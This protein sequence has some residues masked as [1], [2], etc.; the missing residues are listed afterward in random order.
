M[1]NEIRVYFTAPNQRVVKTHKTMSNSDATYGICN[2]AATLTAAKT[3][4]DRAFKLYVRMNLHQDKYTYALSPVEI[5][6][7]I[8]MSDKRYREAVKELIEKGYLV[9]SADHP[10]FFAFYEYP[11]LDNSVSDASPIQVADP[12]KEVTL[13]VEN[14]QPAYPTSP[15]NPSISRGEII[16]DKTNTTNDNTDNNTDNRLADINRILDDVSE[17]ISYTPYFLRNKPV[18]RRRPVHRHDSFQ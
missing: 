1:A 13:S 5:R 9:S 12:A 10:S 7:S 4:S 3:L 18:E 11:Q 6:S 17:A 15:S 8:G 16:H 2:I 14:S